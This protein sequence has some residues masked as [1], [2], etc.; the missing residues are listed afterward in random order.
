MMDGVRGG[1]VDGISC[2]DSGRENVHFGGLVGY[3]ISERETV[4]DSA[5][6][7]SLYKG[8]DENEHEH[9]TGRLTIREDNVQL[10]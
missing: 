10:E 4:S 7:R 5:H 9:S 2:Q 6:I 1:N 3:S 8:R